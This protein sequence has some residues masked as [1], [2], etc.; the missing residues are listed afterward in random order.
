VEAL[1]TWS[2]SQS[3]W[4]ARDGETLKGGETRAQGQFTIKQERLEPGC[5]EK[6]F[7]IY[8]VMVIDGKHLT[9]GGTHSAEL[10]PPGP[11]FDLGKEWDALLN[12]SWEVGPASTPYQPDAIIQIKHKPAPAPKS[13]LAVVQ[14]RPDWA[15]DITGKWILTPHRND[16]SFRSS[17]G[18]PKDTQLTMSIFLANNPRHTKIRRQYWAIFKFGDGIEGCMRF[19]M[20]NDEGSKWTAKEFDEA[21]MLDDDDWVGPSPQGSPKMGYRWRVKNCDTGY[22]PRWYIS[23]FQHESVE[24][25]MGD[26]GKLSFTAIMTVGFSPRILHGVKTG[27]LEPRKSNAATVKTAW[28]SY[29]DIREP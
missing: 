17:I 21:C 27:E 11:D 15:W 7:R 6:V 28:N 4:R 20:L 13:G 12:P 14:A 5:S 10:D 24:F 16:R 23:E 9:F 29:T 1:L 22:Q 8:F 3:R 26:D 19:C 2:L 25:E 18:V